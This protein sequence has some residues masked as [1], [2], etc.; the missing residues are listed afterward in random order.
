MPAVLE[1]PPVA[2]HDASGDL[3]ITLH[4]PDARVEH[5]PEAVIQDLWQH[6]RFR[7]ADLRTSESVPVEVWHPG[8]LNTDAGP[9]FS[10]ARLRIG[11]LA[12]SGD[13]EVHR[14]SGEWVLHRHDEDPRYDRV[15]LHVTLVAD[16]HTGRLRRSDGTVLP[17]VVLYP[18][19]QDSLRALLHRF[20][21]TPTRGLPCAAHWPDA[22]EAL[23]RDL[24]RA[25]GH[26]RLAARRDALADAFL[27][28]PDLDQLLYERTLRALG[29]A[30]NA[31]PM[32]RL[33]RRVPLRRLRTL[34]DLR[35]A[36]ALLFGGAGLL[37]ASGI[38][39]RETEAYVDGLRDRFERLTAD[40]P[41][42]P[43]LAT[44]WT[45][46]RLRAPSLPAR[47]IAQAAALAAPGGLLHRDPVAYLVHA[48]QSEQTAAA[49]RQALTG[50]APSAFWTTHV[51]LD[52]PCKPMSSSIGRRRAEAILV[53]AVFPV[54]LL[55]AEQ[56]GDTPLE[57]R[58]TDLYRQLPAASDEVTRHYERLGTKPANA[59][60]A[61]GL[62]QLY[63]TRCADG[64]C[65]AC[66]VGQWVLSEDGRRRT[67][68]GG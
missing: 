42:R 44:A 30:K 32:E 4:E 31:D 29:Y 25:Y 15:V 68:D 13:V 63:R 41:V 3:L 55:W 59:L 37:P 7:H 46:A 28:T 23:R 33:A 57:A 39:D 60:E 14:T 5:V 58:V 18:R 19:L 43:M 53:N 8:A 64:R 16:R 47:R 49:L 50:A 38:E 9:D 21:A 65:L 34:T 17:E 12:W 26:A 6:L 40:E 67:E 62:H 22:P 10:G 11:D 45:R 35:D 66:S 48:L 24:I 2:Y 52:R 27:T 61:Q 54:L 51:R 20:Y 1:P 56:T 36:E